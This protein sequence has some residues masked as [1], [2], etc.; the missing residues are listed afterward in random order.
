MTLPTPNASSTLA[1]R[2][3]DR[4]VAELETVLEPLGQALGTR[5]IEVVDR[6]PNTREAHERRDAALEFE[7]LR[8]TWL[9]AT[10]LAWRRGAAGLASATAPAGGG[11]LSLIDHDEVERKIIASRLAMA[12]QER[13]KRR[14]ENKLPLYDPYEKQMEFHAAGAS[15]RERLFM[16]GNQ[17]GKTWSGAYEAAYHATG[18]Y[19]DWWVGRRFTKPTVGWAS[20]VTS[21]SVRETTQRLLLGR[22][23]AQI[24]EA[25]ILTASL[26]LTVLIYA[27]IPLASS[28]YALMVISLVIGLIL[29]IGQPLAVSLLHHNAP[30][31][32]SM[33]VLVSPV[34]RS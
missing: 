12:L 33:C 10:R 2:V 28:F 32:R 15:F 21:E 27:L 17:L 25:R 1:R 7:R 22:I 30:P 19:P 18:K 6:S 13:V 8:P 16:A 24:D 11:D 3:R 31:G 14:R 29:G 9:A 34:A 20:G 5:L 4:F 26:L 23:S